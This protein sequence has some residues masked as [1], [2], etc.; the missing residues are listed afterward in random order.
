M[1]EGSS[2]VYVIGCPAPSRGPVKIGWTAGDPQKRLTALRTGDGTI[3][4]DGVDRSGLEVLYSSTGGPTLERALHHR[5]RQLRVTGEW[6][7]LDPAV[8]PREVRMAIAELPA[9]A[10][11]TPVKA[12]PRAVLHRSNQPASPAVLGASQSMATTARQLDARDAEQQYR[13]FVTL[14]TAGFTEDQALRLV[15]YMSFNRA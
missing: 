2:Y 12:G 14:I 3:T 4:P 7:R 1:S 13:Q 10:S 9:M 5:F 15:A 11:A 6:F 8:A